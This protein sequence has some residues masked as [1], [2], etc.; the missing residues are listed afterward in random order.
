MQFQIIENRK[1]LGPLSDLYS[2][3]D[4][5]ELIYKGHRNV[6]VFNMRGQ[7]V[8]RKFIKQMDFKAKGLK[9]HDLYY[10]EKS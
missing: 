3:K 4:I 1:I 6:T 8:T 5:A 9:L 10:G 2:V 7:D